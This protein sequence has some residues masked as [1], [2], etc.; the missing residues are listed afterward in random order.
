MTPAVAQA[1]SR[2]SSLCHLIPFSQVNQQGL[3]SSR[4]YKQ[5]DHIFR[6]QPWGALEHWGPCLDYWETHPRVPKVYGTRV[7]VL[8]YFFL[9]VWSEGQAQDVWPKGS[10]SITLSSRV[11]QCTWNMAP[12]HSSGGWDQSQGQLT[13]SLSQLPDY[14][15]LEAFS[16]SLP[17][18]W[19][20][21][22]SSSS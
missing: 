22:A 13:G 12:F 3:L 2:F 15:L 14:L 9:T 5:E 16:H 1:P 11:E 19:H 21:V 4:F 7:W 8:F 20:L 10:M 17:S 18:L 6:S